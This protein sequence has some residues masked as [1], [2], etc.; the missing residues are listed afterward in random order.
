MLF[1]IPGCLLQSAGGEANRILLASAFSSM[2]IICPNRV[3]RRD[4]IIAVSLGCFVSLGRLLKTQYDHIN[5]LERLLEPAG[6]RMT[7]PSASNLT[8]ASRNFHDRLT[9][10]VGCLVCGSLVANLLSAQANSASYPQR[11]GK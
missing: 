7:P 2:H 8:L 3:S 11:D 4:W 10:K 6:S 1:Q 9:P 5:F